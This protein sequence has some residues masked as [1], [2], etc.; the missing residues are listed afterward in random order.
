[1]VYDTMFVLTADRR[2]C[3]AVGWWYAAVREPRPAHRHDYPARPQRAGFLGSTRGRR[4]SK[5]G[6]SSGGALVSSHQTD[7]PIPPSVPQTV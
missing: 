1:M 4:L 3:P 7:V 6:G 2:A 5:G